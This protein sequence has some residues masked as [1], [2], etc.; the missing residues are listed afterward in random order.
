VITVV[1]KFH[2]HETVWA[3]IIHADYKIFAF[4]LVHEFCNIVVKLVNYGCDIFVNP[5]V[6]LYL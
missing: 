6:L 2:A 4:L 5:M 3:H 1:R